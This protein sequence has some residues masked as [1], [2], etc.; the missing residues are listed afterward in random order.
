[1][2]ST[3]RELV[4]GLPEAQRHLTEKTYADKLRAALD[5]ATGSKV[6]LAFELQSSADTSLAAQARRERAEQKA[7]TEAQFR[8]EPFV[9]DVLARFDA[10]VNPE[11]IKPV[12]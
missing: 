2:R 11:S 3:G 9:R 7:R 12:S 10:S 6:R 5:E 1:V 8:N 4:L